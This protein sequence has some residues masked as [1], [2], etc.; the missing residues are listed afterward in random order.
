[1]WRM[2]T[3]A[4]AAVQV[5]IARE[6]MRSMAQ[7]LAPAAIGKALLSADDLAARAR[8]PGASATASGAARVAPIVAGPGA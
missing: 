6:F 8:G 1:M 5:H 2:L 4:G 7:P 3:R